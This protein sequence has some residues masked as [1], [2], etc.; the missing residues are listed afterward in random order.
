MG[1]EECHKSRTFPVFL[2]CS[3]V[4]PCRGSLAVHGFFPHQPHCAASWGPSA[5]IFFR[6]DVRCGI[7]AGDRDCLL[8]ASFHRSCGL[9]H[10]FFNLGSLKLSLVESIAGRRFLGGALGTATLFTPP[11]SPMPTPIYN[12]PADYER[13]HFADMTLNWAS[14]ILQKPGPV[15]DLSARILATVKD[16]VR[17]MNKANP[18]W[19]EIDPH[20]PH[21]AT[22]A[23]GFGWL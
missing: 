18:T 23:S 4:Q 6:A 9:E 21:Y 1:I 16:S 2:T 7:A 11:T 13:A 12:P 5:S 8:L 15:S 17:G 22:L 19:P 3:V 10:S 20:G 14:Y